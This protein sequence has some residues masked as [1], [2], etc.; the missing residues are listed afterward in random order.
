MKH[1]LLCFTDSNYS[2]DVVIISANFSQL[3]YYSFKGP[4]PYDIE[5]IQERN[6]PPFVGNTV[7]FLCRVT[8]N[9]PSPT[10]SWQGLNDATLGPR[11]LGSKCSSSFLIKPS[12]FLMG[13]QWT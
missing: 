9:G 13:S 12:L 10:P 6:E 3:L 4:L 1:K 5:L 7:S 8:G 11:L 2:R